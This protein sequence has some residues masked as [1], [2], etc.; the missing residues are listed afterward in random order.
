MMFS[1]IR[2]TGSK[3]YSRPLNLPIG[4]DH[5]LRNFVLKFCIKDFKIS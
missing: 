4:Q 2:A 3:F 5:G 1:M